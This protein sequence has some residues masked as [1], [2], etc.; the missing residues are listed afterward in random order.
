MSAI[1]P[2]A[3]GNQWLSWIHLHD[4]VAAITHL[5]DTPGAGGTVYNLTAPNPVRNHE[6][7]STAAR[8]LRRPNVFPLPRTVMQLLLGEQATLVCDG[9]QVLP[10]ELLARGFQFRYPTMEAAL[11]DLIRT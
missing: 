5:I 10:R 2:I 1:A 4:V 11:E 8:L 3:N 7:A 6:F 9:Q